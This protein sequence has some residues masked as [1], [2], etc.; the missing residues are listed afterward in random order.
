M[1]PHAFVNGIAQH[2]EHL[3]HGID[4]EAMEAESVP[5]CWLVEIST[6]DAVPDGYISADLRGHKLGKTT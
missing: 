4:V 6:V 5:V 2:V 3:D 1:R